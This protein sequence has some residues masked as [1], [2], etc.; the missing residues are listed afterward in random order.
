MNRNLMGIRT[1]LL[2]DEI[3][4]R[5]M[6]L[7]RH[8]QRVR[9]V[10]TLADL[11][12]RA[13]VAGQSQGRAEALSAV[14]AAL[15]TLLEDATA[16]MPDVPPDGFGD[17]T[18]AL[19]YWRNGRQELWR[20]VEQARQTYE[21]LSASDRIAA[22]AE[23]RQVELRAAEALAPEPSLRERAGRW[24]YTFGVRIAEGRKVQQALAA[25]QG[26]S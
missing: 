20:L 15:N 23:R 17:D 7:E 1:N 21:A 12:Q 19:A 24:V 9:S 22:H 3:C 11:V 8:A 13:L 2:L 25:R 16:R 14:A 26:A 6:R 18:P 5:V 10:G 4:A